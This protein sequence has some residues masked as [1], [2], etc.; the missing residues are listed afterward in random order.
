MIR[1]F[2]RHAG[3]SARG[4]GTEHAEIIKPARDAHR[5][6]P[7]IREIEADVAATQSA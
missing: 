4:Y 6:E 3:F 5:G 7:S 2:K 1:T